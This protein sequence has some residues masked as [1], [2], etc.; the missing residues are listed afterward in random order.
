MRTIQKAKKVSTV[1]K[2]ALDKFLK[3]NYLPGNG[4]EYLNRLRNKRPDL[5]ERLKNPSIAA[6]LAVKLGMLRLQKGWTQKQAAVRAQIGMA[7]Y[8]NLE[9][10]KPTANPT[11]KVLEGL[12]GAYEVKFEE[13][14]TPEDLLLRHVSKT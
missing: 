2:T 10:A 12:A 11:L 14:F 5:Y 8:Q 3:E 4:P 1:K 6:R 9:E 13:L 7:T